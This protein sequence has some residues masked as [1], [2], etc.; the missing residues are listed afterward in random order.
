MLLKELREQTGLSQGRFAAKFDIP[1]STYCHWEQGLR[2]PPE[3]V[4]SMIS[5]IL[6]QEKQLNALGVGVIQSSSVSHDILSPKDPRSLSLTVGNFSKYVKYYQF[7]V[8]YRRELKLWAE[9]GVFR[10]KKLHDYLFDNRLKYI[11]KTPDQLTD[12]EILRGLTI[13]GVLK[14]YTVF[15]ATTMSSVI[16]D[17]KIQSVYDPCAGWGERLLCCHLKKIPYYG[18]DINA[19]LKVGYDRMIADL[20]IDNAMFEVG[21][22]S[23]MPVTGNFDAIV[24]CPPYFIIEHYTDVGAENLSYSAFLDWWQHVVENSKNCNIRY[25]CFQINQ[26]YREDLTAVVEKCGFA[27]IDARVYKNNKSSHFTR[28]N[29]VNDKK[30]FEVMLVFER[31]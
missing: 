21:D 10:G 25:F 31:L 22:S 19:D 17:Y 16:D 8:F 13:S 9:N 30:E 12:A 6:T 14:S 3:Y 23:V 24:T 11:G 1:L 7:D 28:K 26:K 4:I 15:D 18:V 20:H 27:L 29:G 2:I 5:T